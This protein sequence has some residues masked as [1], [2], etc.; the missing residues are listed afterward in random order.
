MWPVSW[1]SRWPT[2]VGLTTFSVNVT[3]VMR[4]QMTNRCRVNDFLS[5]CDQCYEKADDQPMW[6]NDNNIAIVHKFPFPLP[7]CRWAL[8][9]SHIWSVSTVSNYFL[10]ILWPLLL[11]QLFHIQQFNVRWFWLYIVQLKNSSTVDGTHLIHSFL[12]VLHTADRDLKLRV[13]IALK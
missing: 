6:V 3:S 2:D 7:D 5:K 1:E 9:W 12:S 11:Y 4:K 13:T 10:F 8:G